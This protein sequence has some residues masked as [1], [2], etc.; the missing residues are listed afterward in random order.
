MDKIVTEQ[1]GILAS[2]S[3]LETNEF[4]SRA[5]EAIYD[6]VIGTLEGD[7]V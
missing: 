7:V 5:R 3:C 2:F 6:L 1:N 4:M